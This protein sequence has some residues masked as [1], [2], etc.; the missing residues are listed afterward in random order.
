[1]AGKQKVSR[2]SRSKAGADRTAVLASVHATSRLTNTSLGDVGRKILS[3]ERYLFPL[4][5]VSAG[6]PVR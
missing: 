5:T 4:R 2:R 6:P 1:M 3:R